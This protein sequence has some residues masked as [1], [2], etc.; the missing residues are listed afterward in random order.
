MHRVVAQSKRVEPQK[1]LTKLD[2]TLC[3]IRSRQKGIP[4]EFLS[5][6]SVRLAHDMEGCSDPIDAVL[7]DL[8]SIA[9]AGRSNGRERD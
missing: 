9:K 7:A 4:S 2:F 8:E 3:A 1:A 6:P 5:V